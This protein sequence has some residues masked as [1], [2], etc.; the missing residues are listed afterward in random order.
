MLCH[1]VLIPSP[2]IILGLGYST[3]CAVFPTN[4]NIDIGYST[5]HGAFIMGSQST[6]EDSI[7]LGIFYQPWFPTTVISLERYKET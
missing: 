6:M 1:P 3:I 4:G 2:K 7:N 5:G